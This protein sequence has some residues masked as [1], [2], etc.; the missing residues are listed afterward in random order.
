[1]QRIGV[2]AAS[3]KVPQGHWLLS[4]TP[5]F[6]DLDFSW[7]VVNPQGSMSF[8]AQL[9]ACTMHLADSVKVHVTSRV[10][11][12]F[13]LTAF[14][15]EGW[16]MVPDDP[17]QEL[18]EGDVHVHCFL[19]PGDSPDHPVDAL[20]DYMDGDDRYHEEWRQAS[21]ENWEQIELA[22]RGSTL[23]ELVTHQLRKMEPLANHQFGQ[24]CLVRAVGRAESPHPNAI[25]LANDEFWLLMS[26]R[27]DLSQT[28]AWHHEHANSLKQAFYATS[29]VGQPDLAE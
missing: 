27:L 7:D 19:M 23:S 24:L 18:E 2:F 21:A 8:Y 17:E 1:M 16:V 20:S 22:M 6:A 5:S 25:D 9:G 28:D 4:V 29:R 10:D 12:Q 11:T 3:G 15:D 26:K 14:F 13:S